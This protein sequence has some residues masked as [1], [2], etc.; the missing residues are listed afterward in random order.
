MPGDVTEDGVSARLELADVEGDCLTR[1]DVDGAGAILEYEVVDHRP[2]IG[3]RDGQS[4]RVDRQ[5]SAD[6]E[7]GEFDVRRA[8][9]TLVGCFW[10]RA[11]GPDRGNSR[12]HGGYHG[13]ESHEPKRTVEGPGVVLGSQLILL[14]SDSIVE[15]APSGAFSTEELRVRSCG[16]V[17]VSSAWRHL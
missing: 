13:E 7:L 10:C 4:T 15:K 8:R 6:L 14:V 2:R 5:I 17:R 11:A 3:E 9:A 1:V 16:L 12:E